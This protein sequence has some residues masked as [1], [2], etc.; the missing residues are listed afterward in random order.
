[1]IW[2]FRFIVAYI[3]VLGILILLMKPLY[4]QIGSTCG[5][6]ALIYAVSRVQHINK[7]KVTRRIITDFINSEESFVGEIFDIEKMMEIIHKYFPE[8]KA[9]IVCINGIQDLNQQLENNYVVYPCN[10]KGTPHYYFLEASRK[11]EYIYRHMFFWK[12]RRMGKEE[13]Y[14]QHNNLNKVPEFVWKDY[15]DQE[16]KGLN[17]I[18]EVIWKIFTYVSDHVLYKTLDE[19][20]KQRKDIL[21]DKKTEIN[22]WG[23]IL[24]IP[25]F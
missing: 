24:I 23:K 3:I 17:R 10:Y 22:M 18:Y 2:L 4:Q 8:I 21:Y 13:F 7:K 19:A 16:Y 6:Y 14:F 1:M 20:K 11:S 9:Q 12:R 15:F 5:F 25:K